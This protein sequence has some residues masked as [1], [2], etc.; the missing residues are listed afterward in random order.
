MARNVAAVFRTFPGRVVNGVKWVLMPEE[1]AVLPQEKAVKVSR[2]RTEI[3]AWLFATEDLA[4][5]EVSAET[6]RRR[7]SLLRY[8]FSPETLG[9]EPAPD[10]EAHETQGAVYGPVKWLLSRERLPEDE[11]QSVLPRR[12]LVRY[13]FSA[14]ELDELEEEPPLSRRPLIRWLFSREP[15]EEE[16]GSD[17]ASG[18]GD[19]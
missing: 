19:A 16:A 11:A 4:E 9:E 14:E 17:D 18:P 6:V 5:E 8:I 15:L 2:R 13:V 10:E 12:S 7:R 1:L 3:F